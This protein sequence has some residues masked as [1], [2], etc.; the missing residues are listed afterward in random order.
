MPLTPKANLTPFQKSVA[1]GTLLGDSSLSCPSSGKNFHL[2]CYHSEKQ[3]EWLKLKHQWLSPL[4]R[5]INWCSYTDKRDG[6]TRSGGRFHTVS[7]PCFTEIAS[8][9]YVNR[10]KI[11]SSDFLALFTDPVSLACLICDDGSWDG[12]G[13]AIAS[14]QFTIEE[15]EVLASHLSKTFNLS[16]SVQK[17]QK[18]PYTRIT[19]ISVE[20]THKICRPYIPE[21]LEYKFGPNGYQTRLIGKVQISCI[22]CGKTFVDYKSSGRIACSPECGVAVRANGYST[23]TK[24]AN[25]ERCH[26]S[27]V[28]YNRRQT[29]CER[30]RQIPLEDIPCAI[31]G[32]P[33]KKIGRKTCS[34]RCGVFMGHRNK[35]DRR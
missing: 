30:C 25:C 1:V 10:T 4:S 29:R 11:I 5:P 14:K 22:H 17:N 34:I 32:Q 21:C 8:I 18:Y 15:N 16:V 31:C 3:A 24:K 26:S 23:R 27:F 33:V 2:S 19:A 6:K 13:I 20:R 28:V 35:L 7:I 9:L 12:A